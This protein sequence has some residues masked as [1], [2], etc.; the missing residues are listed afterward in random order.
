MTTEMETQHTAA[1][2]A[3]AGAPV[4][5]GKTAAKKVAGQKKRAPKGAKT[6]KS[7]KPVKAAKKT[8]RKDGPRQQSK[9]ATILELIR[10]AKGA[11]LAEIME[12]TGWQAHSVRGFISTAGKKPGVRIESQKNDTGARLY[13]IAK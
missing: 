2:V 8:A 13:R 9:G 6:A 10:R 3:E 1:E 5:P 11:S 4:T 12:A 7:R